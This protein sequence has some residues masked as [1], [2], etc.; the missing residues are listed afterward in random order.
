M[1]E[2]L[3][4]V[5][6]AGSMFVLVAFCSSSA[7]SSDDISAR[8]DEVVSHY[9]QCGYFQGVGLVAEHGQIFYSGG[10][11]EVD[12]AK[13]VPNTSQTKFGI[14]SITKQFTAALVLQQAAEGRIRLDGTVSEYLPW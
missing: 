3:Q 11:G 14:A 10:V 12:L 5:L 13:H 7:A 2:T 9:A 6:I 1:K 4:Q 8:F